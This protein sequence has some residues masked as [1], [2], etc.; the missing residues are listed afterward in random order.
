MAGEGKDEGEGEAGGR[1]G[2]NMKE[3]SRHWGMGFQ[4]V[5]VVTEGK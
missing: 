3:L 5:W 4:R 2:V 1:M